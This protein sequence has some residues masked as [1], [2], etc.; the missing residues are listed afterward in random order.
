MPINLATYLFTYFK[1]EP[2]IYPLPFHISVYFG[3]DYLAPFWYYYLIPIGGTVILLGHS[4]AAKAVY[5]EDMFL[6]QLLLITN[7][8]INAYLFG[9]VIFL[10]RYLT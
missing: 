1:V 5:R 3:I 2:T 4:L 7:I 6:A 8:F 10:V 9:I